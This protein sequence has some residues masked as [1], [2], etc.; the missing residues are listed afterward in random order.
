MVT[1]LIAVCG[2]G[3]CGGQAKYSLN[4]ASWTYCVQ[5]ANAEGRKMCSRPDRVCTVSHHA[6]LAQQKPCESF[7][8]GTNS[9]QQGS[10]SL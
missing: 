4:V 3:L 8:F 7:D 10:K 9:D 2:M 5:Y 1:E 6:S